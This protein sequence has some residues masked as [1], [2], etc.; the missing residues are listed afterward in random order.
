MRTRALAV[1]L[2]IV[3][4]AALRRVDTVMQY[5]LSAREGARAAHLMFPCAPDSC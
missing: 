4:S 3:V 1:P 5:V 2:D